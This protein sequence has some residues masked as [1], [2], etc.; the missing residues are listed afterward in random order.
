MFCLKIFFALILLFAEKALWVLPFCS[1]L[2]KK[3]DNFK[4]DSYFFVPL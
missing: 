1:W 4:Y 3:T 2:M